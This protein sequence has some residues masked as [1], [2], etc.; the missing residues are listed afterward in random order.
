MDSKTRMKNPRDSKM[1]FYE[2]ERENIQ[3]HIKMGN[4]F[5]RKKKQFTFIVKKVNS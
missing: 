5:S 4:Q 2:I 1:S 3:L